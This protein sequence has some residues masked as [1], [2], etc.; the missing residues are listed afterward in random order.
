MEI[1]LW[2]P[3][4]VA[5]FIEPTSARYNIERFENSVQGDGHITVLA[6]T[7]SVLGEKTKRTPTA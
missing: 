6:T 5:S 4:L 1:K 3:Q 7:W 2:S